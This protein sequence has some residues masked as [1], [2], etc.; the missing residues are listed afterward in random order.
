MAMK[1]LIDRLKRFIRQDKQSQFIKQR[2]SKTKALIK[3]R[4]SDF[5][6]W[7]KDEELLTNW[8]ERTTILASYVLPNTNVIKFGAG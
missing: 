1:P 2:E 8:N 5:D 4:L 3:D 6:R 7:Q